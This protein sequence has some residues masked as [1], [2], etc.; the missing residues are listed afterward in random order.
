M[1]DIPTIIDE[2]YEDFQKGNE[3]LHLG[4]S[5]CIK[6]FAK[7]GWYISAEIELIDTFELAKKLNKGDIESLDKFL[8][9]H[10]SKNIK[11]I[12]KDKIKRFP[13]RAAILQQA[14]TAHKLKLYYAS[15]ILF[16]TQADGI[17][18]GELFKT[19]NEKKALKKYLQTNGTPGFLTTF[20]SAITEE[21]AIDVYHP[22]KKKYKS[23]LNRHGVMHG[24]DFDYGT[25]LNSLKAL[26]LLCF[27]TDFI[28][29]HKIF[30]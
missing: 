22:D 3:K 1:I 13:E 21:S 17:C 30:V 23:D 7:Y 26:S 19:R 18:S 12:I 15:T 20:L 27:V 24:F 28:N 29:R 4:L 14:R 10:F 11:Q 2:S 6:Q 9:N 5:K 8:S 16:L 25:E